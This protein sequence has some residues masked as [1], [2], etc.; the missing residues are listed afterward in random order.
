VADRAR[1]HAHADLAGSRRIDADIL[2]DERLAERVAHGCLHAPE[3]Y[4]QG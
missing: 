1:G 4:A 2:D 3:L